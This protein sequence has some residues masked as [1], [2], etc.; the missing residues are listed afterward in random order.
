HSIVATLPCSKVLPQ[1]T[2]SQEIPTGY[3][4]NKTWHFRICNYTKPDYKTCFINKQV[5]IFGD[6]NGRS[7]YYN[8][9]AHSNCTEVKKAETR[10]W[11]KPLLC[12]HKANN[13]SVFWG[14]HANPFSNGNT[15]SQIN[16]LVPTSK[17]IDEIP[18]Q[19]HYLIIMTHYYH[20]TASH[21][22]SA[23]IMFRS[24]KESLVRLLKRN[25]NVQVLLQGPHVAWRGWAEHYAAGDMLGTTIMEMQREIFHDIR[26]R[27][28][29]YSPWDITIAV[30][31]LDYHP[32]IN[33]DIFHMIFAF[34]CGR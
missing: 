4:S 23:E 15:V 20:F 26:D 9:Q 5:L 11:H 27:V 21:I 18:S 12:E 28:V 16:D 8:V 3:M 7:H 33:N 32:S 29:F 14:P 24:I 19:G 31:N 13:F 1:L 6:S 22:S 2:W 25:P 10:H 34:L 17:A 30:E